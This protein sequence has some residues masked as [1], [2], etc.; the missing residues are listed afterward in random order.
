MGC[1]LGTVGRIDALSPRPAK[2][3]QSNSSPMSSTDKP[4]SMS[5]FIGYWIMAEAAV[6]V[7]TSH[8]HDG[9]L[10]TSNAEI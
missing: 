8:P 2:P 3:T 1:I 7:S 6:I 9:L 5:R 10:L 4:A